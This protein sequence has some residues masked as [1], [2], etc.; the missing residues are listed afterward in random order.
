MPRADSVSMTREDVITYITAPRTASLA[1]SRRRRAP[2]RR[3][4]VVRVRRRP[5]RD[6]DLRQVPEGR[7]PAPRPVGVRCTG[8]QATPTRSCAVSSSRPKPPSP[9]IRRR[10]STTCAP[11]TTPSACPAS[12]RCLTRHAAAISLSHTS[13]SVSPCRSNGSAAG[14]TAKPH[15]DR[16]NAV[17]AKDD[18]LL[19]GHHPHVAGSRSIRRA[20]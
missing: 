7:Q 17:M 1:T 16:P 12:G 10:S 13:E 2:A 11:S 6:G 8:S 18:Q 4:D 9:T 5:R 19:D 20:N 15:R 3:G 14:T